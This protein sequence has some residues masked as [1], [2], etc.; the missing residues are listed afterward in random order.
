MPAGPDIV[1][2]GGLTEAAPLISPDGMRAA[3]AGLDRT[4][5]IWDVSTGEGLCP[6][7][8]VESRVIRFIQSSDGGWLGAGTEDGSVVFWNS[9]SGQRLATLRAAAK[10]V[11]ALQISR[12]GQTLAAASGVFVELWSSTNAM[13]GR[14]PTLRLTNDFAVAN[15]RLTHDG[16]RALTWGRA[17]N[18]PMTLWNTATGSRVLVSRPGMQT[19]DAA[20]DAT[21]SRLASVSGEYEA[22]IWDTALQRR[23][24]LVKS[25]HS[26]ITRVLLDLDG[27]RLVV[28]YLLGTMQIFDAET[29]LPLAGQMR[30]LYQTAATAL[31]DSGERLVTGAQDFTARVW[32]STTGEALC[33]PIPHAGPVV[34]VAHA[35]QTDRLLVVNEMPGGGSERLCTWELRSPLEP[36]R[37]QPPGARDLSDIQLS[38]DGRWV[39]VPVWTPSYALWIYDAATQRPVIGPGELL[40]DAYAIEF[41]PDMRRLVIATANGW[42]HGWWVADWQPLW[43]PVRQSG[44]I[45]PA[46]LSP[47]GTFFATGGPDGYLRL[48]DVESGRF[49]L[50]LN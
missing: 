17:Y 23:L 45:Q 15:V 42:L 8:P 28:V 1:H 38:P 5:R 21:G 6:P 36:L 40:G 32:D 26:S 13:A 25:D 18:E 10:P 44:P 11:T 22:S 7:L 35:A 24:S 3:T 34:H 41:T 29:G 9:S 37:F 43:P 39:V 27:E 30:H 19:R 14:P 31:D 48:F 4:V 12:D 16:R 46:A 50:E 49:L 2:P 33:E 47:D 20:L